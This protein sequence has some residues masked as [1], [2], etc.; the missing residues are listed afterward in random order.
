[1]QTTP[2]VIVSFLVMLFSGFHCFALGGVGANAECAGEPIY[3]NFLVT[4]ETTALPCTVAGNLEFDT[5]LT[6]QHFT[7]LLKNHLKGPHQRGGAT[8]TT[9]SIPAARSTNIAIPDTARVVTSMPFAKKIQ[10]SQRKLLQEADLCEGKLV[11]QDIWVNDN[12]NMAHLPCRCR[13]INVRRTGAVSLPGV[14]EVTGAVKIF[15]NTIESLVMDD[16]VTAK[17]IDSESVSAFH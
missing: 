13:N 10:R 7:T 15:E 9:T 2:H 3:G 16:L 6:T 1:M 11:K 8:T 12:F 4:N 17:K 14:V 5:G